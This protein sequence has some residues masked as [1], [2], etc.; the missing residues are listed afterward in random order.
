MREFTMTKSL[1]FVTC[2]SGP[3][4]VDATILQVVIPRGMTPFAYRNLRALYHASERIAIN[5]WLG[6]MDFI[7]IDYC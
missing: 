1:P 3:S 5:F 6:F 2:L 4:G 7:K